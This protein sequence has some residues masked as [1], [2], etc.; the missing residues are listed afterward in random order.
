MTEQ[1]KAPFKKYGR[2]ILVWSILVVLVVIG[3]LS[4]LDRKVIA[5]GV[6]VAG[7][8][9]QAFSGLLILVGA[10]PV[11]GP[12]VVQIITLPFFL[13]VNGI[14]YLVTFLAIKR[15]YKADVLKT[16]VIVSALLVGIIVGFIIGR[17]L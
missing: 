8:I 11:V 6:V 16:K 10:V 15:G 5:V 12:F 17:V 4:G 2:L 9:T 14:A 7:L 1:A 13:L 3:L